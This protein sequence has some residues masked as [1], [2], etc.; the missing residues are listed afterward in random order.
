MSGC[1]CIL[2][3]RQLSLLVSKDCQ[4]FHRSLT[5]LQ[6]EMAL[7]FLPKVAPYE[8]S[9]EGP[10]QDTVII[11]LLRVVWALLLLLGTVMAMLLLPPLVLVQVKCCCF[12]S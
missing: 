4:D 1:S 6:G 8:C 3:A 7:A 12:S 9:H 2:H 10:L 5:H 11:G